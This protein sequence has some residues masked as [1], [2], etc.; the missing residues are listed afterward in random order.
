MSNCTVFAD[1]PVSTLPGST[2]RPGRDLI[3]RCVD[4]HGMTWFIE[5][6]EVVDGEKFVSFQL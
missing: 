5:A 3:A 1:V 6:S 4:Q 2:G